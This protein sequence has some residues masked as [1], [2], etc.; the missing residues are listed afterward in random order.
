MCAGVLFVIAGP[1][2]DCQ[3][4]RNPNPTNQTL[5]DTGWGS[6]AYGQVGDGSPNV[7]STARPKPTKVA[8]PPGFVPFT[9]E[10]SLSASAHTACITGSES[11]NSVMYCWGN[12][13]DQKVGQIFQE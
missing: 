10:N 11:D 3:V 12:L 2:N 9:F 6:N 5:L 7:L 8:L 13:V 4:L 1:K